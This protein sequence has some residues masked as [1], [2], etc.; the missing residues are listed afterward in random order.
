MAD[1]DTTDWEKGL[2]G[3]V[4]VRELWILVVAL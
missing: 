4:V 2:T 1:E 3:A